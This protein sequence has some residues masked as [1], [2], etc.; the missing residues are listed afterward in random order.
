MSRR[1]PADFSG[2]QRQRICIARAI[3]A[4]PK[5]IVLDEPTTGLDVSIQSQILNL[6]SDL[7][8]RFALGY[9]FISHNLPLIRHVSDEV[10]VMYLGRFVEKGPTSSLFGQTSHPYTKSLLDSSPN[11]LEVR[12]STPTTTNDAVEPGQVSDV[13]GCRFQVRCPLVIDVCRTTQPPPFAVAP[14]HFSECWR[15]GDLQAS[16][17][18]RPSFE[19]TSSAGAPLAVKSWNDAR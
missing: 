16:A 12:R 19:G 8:A 18:N 9:V 4:E 17:I 11:L 15:V 1:L 6:L 7:Q 5:L 2:G 13:G 3:A 14:G 10:A